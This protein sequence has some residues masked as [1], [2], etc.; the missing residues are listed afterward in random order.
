MGH[1]YIESR[2][3]HYYE[4]GNCKKEI[5]IRDGDPDC[6]EELGPQSDEVE[7]PH[8]STEDTVDNLQDLD[9]PN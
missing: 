7:C 9:L 1:K 3:V 5:Q 6:F 8:C 2:T 4:C